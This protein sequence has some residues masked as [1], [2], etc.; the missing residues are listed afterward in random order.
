MIGCSTLQ[1][2]RPLENTP[3]PEFQVAPKNLC[4]CHYEILYSDNAEQKH[5]DFPQLRLD[6]SEGIMVP[7]AASQS[8]QH[9]GY[10]ASGCIDGLTTCVSNGINKCNG[11]HTSNVGHRA[12]WLLLKFHNRVAVTKVEMYSTAAHGHRTKDIEVRVIEEQPTSLTG[13]AMYTGGQLLG[14]FEGPGAGAQI[15][16][17]S[18]SAKIGRY[19]LIQM[20]SPIKDVMIFQ[21]VFV[22]GRVSHHLTDCNGA[23]QLDV[24]N[25]K[26]GSREDLVPNLLNQDENEWR[27]DE[28]TAQDQGFVLMIRG[29]ERN[30]TGLR[31]RNAVQPWASQRFK[32]SGALDYTGPWID[33]V[34]G[35]LNKTDAI[36]TFHFSQPLKV[37]FLRFDLLSYYSQRGGGLNFFSPTAGGHYNAV[38][39]T[40]VYFPTIFPSQKFCEHF[41][42]LL[43]LDF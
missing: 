39:S 27:T 36:L 31:I 11:C 7:Y 18:G 23:L 19:V 25:S 13:G 29:C 1:T 4:H 34:E 2:L 35:E 43:L 17:V 40:Q 30:I 6:V 42:E 28:S 10:E 16:S 21:E 32:V 9:G 22:F 20:N 41:K 3:K 14:T 26:E 15:I 37:Q 12:P 33:L 24:V 5:I 38:K 8:S